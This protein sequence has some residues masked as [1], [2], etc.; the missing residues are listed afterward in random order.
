MMVRILF[1]VLMLGFSNELIAYQNLPEYFL[2]PPI[3]SNEE[4]FAIGLGQTEEAAFTQA[5]VQLAEKVESFRTQEVENFNSI[6]ETTEEST[7]VLSNLVLNQQ[8]LRFKVQG[9]TK[10]FREEGSDG[11]LISHTIEQPSKLTYSAGED[12]SFI[13]EHFYNYT[14][15]LEG[16]DEE[17][18]G[19]ITWANC[20][21]RHSI[22][23]IEEH[24]DM[25]YQTKDIL[26]NW[27][28]LVSLKTSEISLS[29]E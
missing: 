24:S 8:I 25:T 19:S 13:I 21:F 15:N 10:E 28:T 1:L 20:A 27:Y 5:M 2:S 4:L 17:T 22:R 29:D 7:S 26:D 12:C 16:E 23:F 6:S 3:D 9:F 18:V 11:E 14:N